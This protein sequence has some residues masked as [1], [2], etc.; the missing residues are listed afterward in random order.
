V[1]SADAAA[2]SGSQHG[3]RL[4]DLEGGEESDMGIFQY[5]SALRRRQTELTEY[6]SAVRALP[7]P[8]PQQMKAFAEYVSESHSWYKRLPWWPWSVAFEVY[9]D[10]AAGM[11]LVIDGTGSVVKA[12]E[13]N[14]P[15]FH[16]ASLKTADHLSRFGHLTYSDRHTNK[17]VLAK[18]MRA[19]EEID[20][21][22]KAESAKAKPPGVN[23]YYNLKTN[24][25][26]VLP[27][28]VSSTGRFAVNALIHP[29]SCSLQT[30]THGI[31]RAAREA[32]KKSGDAKAAPGRDHLER[33]VHARELVRDEK[34]WP[35]P[36]ASGGNAQLLLIIDRTIEREK[37]RVK[38]WRI[39]HVGT[40]DDPVLEDL[41]RPER[42]RQLNEIAAACERACA[43]IYDK[44]EAPA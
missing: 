10:P 26:C 7:R 21:I 23:R 40:A 16:Y 4:R 19:S 14:E 13:R 6:R 11:D 17:L 28:S 20:A 12:A 33:L 5:H 2:I 42:Q 38:T 37:S 41:I 32:Q 30:V 18:G 15:G 39:G 3:T 1:R 22:D 9:L 31:D 27:A 24:Q 43:L 8:G 35:W 44:E 36:E 25:H 34:L 29:A